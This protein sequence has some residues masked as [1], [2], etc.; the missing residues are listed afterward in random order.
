MKPK[1]LQLIPR[2]KPNSR[3]SPSAK[4]TLL[5]FHETVKMPLG[6]SVSRAFHICDPPVISRGSNLK[7]APVKPASHGWET[8]L[9][10]LLMQPVDQHKSSLPSHA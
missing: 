6:P 8:V 7:G 2:D 4:K 9:K 10:S 1:V 5:F 3:V